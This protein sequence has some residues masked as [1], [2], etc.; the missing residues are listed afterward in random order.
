MNKWTTAE[1]SILLEYA[2]KKYV[3]EIATIVGRSLFAIQRKTRQLGLAGVP[4]GRPR[5]LTPELIDVLRNVPAGLSGR[6]FAE[7][8]GVGEETVR[9]WAR[10]LGIRFAP[11]SRWTEKQN[12]QLRDLAPMHTATEIAALIG[13]SPS[14]IWSKAHILGVELVRK[15]SRPPKGATRAPKPPKA[16]PEPKLCR[17]PKTNAAPAKAI[18]PID[19][20]TPLWPHYSH[21]CRAPVSNWSEHY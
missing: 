8:H 16:A 2:G 19:E 14:A 21:I 17:P 18:A 3:R 15:G 1:L 10:R 11:A 6:Q 5:T 12:Q 13:R 4:S 7:M 9:Y 20:P